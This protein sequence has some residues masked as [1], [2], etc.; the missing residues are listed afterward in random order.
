MSSSLDKNKVHSLQQKL[1]P[2]EQL[3]PECFRGRNERIDEL[4]EGAR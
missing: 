1:L 3:L 2:Y 4:T